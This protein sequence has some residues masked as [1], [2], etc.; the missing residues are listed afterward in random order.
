MELPSNTDYSGSRTITTNELPYPVPEEGQ[1]EEHVL[2][3]EPE[4]QGRRVR[5]ANNTVDNE[6]LNKKKSKGMLKDVQVLI[7]GNGIIKDDL[8]SFSMHIR[9]VAFTIRLENLMKVHR[10]PTAT[11][12]LQAVA[13]MLMN[14]R[15]E[16][17]CKEY[18][19]QKNH[20]FS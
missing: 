16:L 6:N 1:F 17:G 9:Y 10:N 11:R 12:I 18:R 8:K 7:I 20:K 15:E 19:V 2:R 13:A 3:L 4:S 14:V 5:W